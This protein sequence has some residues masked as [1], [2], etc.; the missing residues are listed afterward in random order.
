MA[1]KCN[2]SKFDFLS[3][4][5]FLLDGAMGTMLQKKGLK[6]GEQPE[7][8]NITH[9]DII[10]DIYREYISAGSQI[11]YTNT[12]G[13]NEKKLAG[14]GYS[15]E[16]IISAAIANAKKAT[17]GSNVKVGLDVGPIGE[18]LEPTGSLPFEDAY[19]I[20]R[21]QIHCAIIHG[22]DCI[23]FETMTDLYELK[24]AV[25]AAK[26]EMES[27]GISIPIM[28][29]MTFEANQH[30]F[31]GCS[32]SAMALTLEGLGVDAIGF[33]CSLGPIE[34]L[35][36]AKELCKWT[37]L[38]IIIK[39][40]AGLPNPETNQYD[41]SPEEFAAQLAPYTELGIHIF[42]GCCGTT[43]EYI[44]AIK[45]M[46]Q[47]KTFINRE[48]TLYKKQIVSA[49]CSPTETVVI[50]RVRII[51]ERINPTGKK[52]FKQALIDSNMDYILTQ[53]ITQVEAGAAI[54]DVN[55][56][57]P[58][59][60]ESTM[61]P[62]VVKK[63]QSILPTPLQIDTSNIQA[64]EAALRVYNG[65]PIVN[66]VNGEQAN[67]EKI[68]PLVK[69]YGASIVGLTLDETGIPL[70]AGDRFA[71]A[72]R[73]VSTAEK[74]GIPKED[75]FIDCLTLTASVQQAEV[76]ETLKAVRMVREQLGV[77]AV[78]GVSNISFGLPNREL[79]NHSFLLLALEA[80]LDLPILNPNVPSMM[81]AV[82]A[83]EVLSNKDI[84][85]EN[86]IAKYNN[87]VK[88]PAA[89][90]PQTMDIDYAIRAGLSDQVAQI[91]KTLLQTEDATD[92]INTRL[93][94]ALDRVGERFEKGEIFLP[95]MIQSA[96][97]AQAAFDVIKIHLSKN[98]KV[99]SQSNQSSVKEKGIVLATVK[100]DI[101]DIGKNIVKVILENYGFPIIDLGRDV[102]VQTI[103]DA[104]K[105]HNVQLCGLSALMTTTLK[106]MEETIQ[107]LHEQTPHV[108]IWVGGAVLTSDYAK[109]IGADFYAKDAKQSVDIAKKVLSGNN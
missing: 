28:A 38:P 60:D 55:V 4:D 69:K 104:V 46:L 37:S 97:A 62:L 31:T 73:I 108:K 25:L 53:G 80:G 68:F 74:Y 34:I 50:D 22:V 82:A 70:K 93:I 36:L 102:P 61:L 96:Q 9:P 99:D 32:V 89:P 12:F 86:Y 5:F 6:L 27:V 64:M 52:L 8:L 75:V 29:S 45:K 58:E 78:L 101:H 109:K 81:D 56:G 63:L 54:L 83:F 100:G 18:L 43:P 24:A 44:S 79:I 106:S 13:A 57:L 33:N 95:Q 26:E 3:Q 42:G 23:V 49:V 84:H 90:T 48:D 40:N 7:L 41:I 67:M 30:T 1:N 2:C 91:T 105:Q 85:A 66:S 39:P 20:Y 92:I 21:R 71:I 19:Q 98:S 72:E 51:G 76:A 87:M 88:T 14:S 10:T 107:A 65:K 17:Q 35:P 47:G 11:V 15:V 16:E 77:H 59:I 103:V 94:P